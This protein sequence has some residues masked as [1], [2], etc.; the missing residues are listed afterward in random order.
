MRTGEGKTLTATLPSYLNALVRP[1]RARRHGERLP[2]PPRRR[3]DG[4]GPPLPGPDHGLHPPRPVRQASARTPYRARHHLRAEQRVRLRLPARQHEVPPAGLRP[5][6]AQLR[7]R[8]RGGL[9]SSSTRRARR[10][11]SPAPPR[12]PPTSTTGSTRSSRAWC[13]TRTTRST[14]R[15]RSVSASP[16]TA[17]RSSRSG[18]AIANL[19]DPSEIETLH[20]VE[21]AP[22]RAHALQARPRLRGEGRRGD[23][24]R[25]VHRPP[26]AGP[27]LV[28]TAC[29]RRSRPR[30]A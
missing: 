1:R 11:S 14:R 6:R 18:S 24:R 19:Y 16:T 12:T 10:S 9:A 23:H 29:T 28:A 3:V 26:D 27:P 5:A 8:R 22:A 4:P 25:R 2:R 7:H 30:K 21:Q 20:H 13:R 17:W 15:H